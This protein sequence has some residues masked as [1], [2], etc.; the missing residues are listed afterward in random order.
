MSSPLEILP[1]LY[2][3]LQSDMCFKAQFMYHLFFHEAFPDFFSQKGSLPPLNSH[4][5]LDIS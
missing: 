1:S 3:L 5:T 4:S 2:L